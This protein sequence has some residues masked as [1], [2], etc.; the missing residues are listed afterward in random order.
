MSEVMVQPQTSY[1]ICA[2][3]RS[4]SFLL[5]EAL[6]NTGVAGGP[7]E[8]FWKGNEAGFAD[9]WDVSVSS[10][11]DYL[12]KAMEQGSTPNGVFGAKIMW[13]YFED[14]VAKLRQI[15][16]YAAVPFP[17]L[18][19]TV[20]PNLHYIHMTRR[21][22]VRQAVSHWKALQTN[23]WA[24]SGEELPL[25]ATEPVFDFAAI[26]TIV[27]ATVAH[28]AAWQQYFAAC[29]VQP[30]TLVYEDL[31]AS[32]EE[33]VLRVLTYLEVVLPPQVAFGPRRMRKQADAQSEEW[34]QRYLELVQRPRD[35]PRPLASSADDV[36]D[37]NV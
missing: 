37:R 30:L 11:A 23:V 26:D 17:R 13:G 32:Y 4:G 31:V 28:D 7:G 14:F 22:K 35:Q 25:P 34:V 2:T 18:L 24:W 5:C 1:L 8:Y 21:D 16:A 29:G 3:P 15:P 27:Q 20:F 33:S 12:A 9:R 10:Y 36:A 19:A 6:I